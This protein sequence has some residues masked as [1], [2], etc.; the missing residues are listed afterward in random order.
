MDQRKFCDH[1]NYR[2]WNRKDQQRS[3]ISQCIKAKSTLK[4]NQIKEKLEN[5]L[6]IKT[7]ELFDI[8]DKILIYDLT[9]TYFEGEK[10]N[11]KLAK[12]GRSKENKQIA[13]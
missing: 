12:F 7:N 13:D 10:R 11:T 6:S 4:L 8:Q 2:I 5:H 1:R 3:T 9:N